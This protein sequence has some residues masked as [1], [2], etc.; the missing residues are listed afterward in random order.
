MSAY[1]VIQ[2]VLEMST[3]MSR[4]AFRG[5][6]KDEWKLDSA[7]VRR[8]EREYGDESP[9]DKQE[10][11]ELLRRYHTDELIMPMKVIGGD[12]LNELQALSVLQ[13]QGA[14]TMLL[15]FTENALVALWFASAAEDDGD[16]KVFAVDIGDPFIWT[17]GRKL[18]RLL[19]TDQESVYYEPDRSLGLRIVA[20][21]S[22]FVVCN[23]R[24]PKRVVKE[25]TVPAH[26]KLAVRETLERLGI[27]EKVL[28]GDVPGLAA[29][30]AWEKPLQLDLAWTAEQW[31]KRGNLAYQEGQFVDALAAYQEYA[32]REPEAAEPLLLIGNALAQLQKYRQAVEAYGVA[33]TVDGERGLNTDARGMLHY[34]RGNAYAVLGDHEAAVADFDKAIEYV[35]DRSMDARYNRAN[36]RYSLGR[37]ED[38]RKD[39][40]DAG[41][42]TRSNTA[43]AMGNCQMMLGRFDEAL[44]CYRAGYSV[45]SRGTAEHCRQNGGQLEQLLE[46]LGDGS[47]RTRVA[48]DLG[49]IEIDRS[50]GLIFVFVGNPGNRGNRW[51]GDGYEGKTG[52]IVTMT[53]LTAGSQ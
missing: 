22:V 40:S 17:N 49:R 53:Q 11:R 37:F 19:D 23:P 42:S 5:H 39:Y 10:L 1:D 8:L 7:A 27:S 29:L 2:A 34:N 32:E 48:D 28:F 18:G 4:P 43:L 14:A 35:P 38:A 20:Q 46:A 24:I 6:A 51:G 9:Q 50:G 13:H 3:T 26:A 41:G 44:E 30:N 45:D 21:Q 12:P 25:V 33:D 31:R 47:Y 36:S 16:G 52:F 15:D